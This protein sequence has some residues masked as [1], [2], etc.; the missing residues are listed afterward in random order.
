MHHNTSSFFSKRRTSIAL[1]AASLLTQAA[2]AQNTDTTSNITKS[3]D[4][5]KVTSASGFERKITDAPA[6]VSV[7]TQEDL[8]ENKYSNLGEMLEDMEGID[9]RMSNTGK[10]GGLSVSIRGMPAEYTLILVDGRRVNPAGSVTP[11]GF[12]ETENNFIPPMSAIERVEVI[13]GPMGTLYGSDAMGGVIN[14]ITK[15]VAN[16]WTGS[17]SSDYT[18][19]ENSGFGDARGTSV[20]L[21]GPIVKD[22]LGIAL[23]GNIYNRDSST[24]NYNDGSN[25]SQRGP[26]PVEGKRWGL[27][28][29]LTFTP[30]E[31]HELWLDADVYRQWY[32]NDR[33]QL[34]T[35]DTAT[36][37]R[38]YEDEL[39]FNRETISAGYN[40]D[41]DIGR[42]ETSISRAETETLGRTL[43]GTTGALF[44]AAYPEMGKAGDPRTLKG[45]NTIFDT[46]FLTTI[47]NSHYLI[48][49]GQWW[50]AEVEDGVS[51]EK[52]EQKT[53]SLFAEDEW[54]ILDSLSLTFGGRYDHHDAF[55]GEF[56]PRIYAVW[57]PLDEWT[58]KG[59]VSKGYKAPTVNDLHEGVNGY[60]AQ[61]T[62]ATIGSP[63]L[64]PETS[65][66][67]EAGVYYNAI[68]G[69]KTNLTVFFNQFDDKIAT[70]DT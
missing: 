11:N 54:Q 15:K 1:V 66:N 33:E 58:F 12:G 40:A 42:L 43:P 57:N 37:A 48:V 46:K 20:Y 62:R 34:G 61:G 32:N 8:Q 51:R 69:F 63:D 6:T 29:K 26:A 31:N 9:V 27:G 4:E 5:I 16:E 14:I 56:S 50:K 30:V 67:Y 49:G 24:L 64:K 35:L 52:F 22:K 19:N 7:V 2:F 39:R 70:G 60:T 47:A 45:T 38:G 65:L 68:S 36:T 41:F 18:F 44:V 13:K 17:I 28:G 3:L 23:R 21:S 59:G 10:T 55:G 25:V 53:W